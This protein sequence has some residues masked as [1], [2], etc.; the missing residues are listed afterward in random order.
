MVFNITSG[1]FTAAVKNSDLDIKLIL[2]N[3]LSAPILL[4]IKFRRSSLQKTKAIMRKQANNLH[5][6]NREWMNVVGYRTSRA[7]FTYKHVNSKLGLQH[8]RHHWQ[9]LSIFWAYRNPPIAYDMNDA[10]CVKGWPHYR[11]NFPCS[12]RTVVWFLSRPLR[13]WLMKEGWR[14]QGQPL[15]VT[16]QW[17]DY[18]NQDKLLN[19]SQHDLTSLSKALVVVPAGV[20]AHDLPLGSLVLSQL[21]WANRA[22]VCWLSSLSD[23]PQSFAL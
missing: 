20:W 12:F 4:M 8:T 7:L 1:D 9:P 21:N 15:K 10:W 6:L 18:L 19:H 14:R 3:R 13:F 16:A 2:S 17:R 5:Y 11:G 22:A 23:V